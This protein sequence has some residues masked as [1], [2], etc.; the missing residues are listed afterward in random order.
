MML[1]LS[2]HIAI[3]SLGVTTAT[4]PTEE[5]DGGGTMFVLYLSEP[6]LLSLINHYALQRDSKKKVFTKGKERENKYLETQFHREEYG[7]TN[8][9]CR[10]LC[11]DVLYCEL[12]NSLRSRARTD[13]VRFVR[14]CSL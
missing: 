11:S 10:Y 9:K 6:V 13:K 14:A 4:V 12:R 1:P 5:E 8:S 7:G 2:Q 3:N